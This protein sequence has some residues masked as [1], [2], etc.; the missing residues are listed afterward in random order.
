MDWIERLREISN[1][2]ATLSNAV[3]RSSRLHVQAIIQAPV[4]VRQGPDL[5]VCPRAPSDNWASG[6]ESFFSQ[7]NQSR[8]RI[9]EFKRTLT[10]CSF[11]VRSTGR[12]VR[13]VIGSGGVAGSEKV[14]LTE[15]Q[16][17][18]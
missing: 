11:H 13:A 7:F 8:S 15:G 10:E 2:T 17:N 9:F 5:G 16:G 14:V 4:E 12:C 6:K 18:V 1:S 3:L